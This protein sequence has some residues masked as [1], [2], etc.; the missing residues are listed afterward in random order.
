MAAFVLVAYVLLMVALGQ[1]FLGRRETLRRVHQP[2]ILWRAMER[3]GDLDTSVSI[4]CLL[5]TV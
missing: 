5:C 4:F 3:F 1:S 2:V